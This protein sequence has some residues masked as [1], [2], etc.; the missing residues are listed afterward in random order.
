[1][2]QSDLPRIAEAVRE[3][4][5]DFVRDS[6]VRVA[7]LI[8][9]S[10]QVIAQHGFSRSLELVNV[11]SLA[12][13][14]HAASRTLARIA[15]SPAWQQTYHRGRTRQLFLAPLDMPT[16][17]L[18]LVAIFDE[19]SSVGLARLFFERFEERIR[20]LPVFG[21]ARPTRK[22]EDFEQDLEAGVQRL[23]PE[24]PPPEG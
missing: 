3:P 12:A 21:A 16:G 4:V 19:H 13:A 20:A 10:G 23:F 18:I 24:R 8:S 11:A 17:E 22:A 6:R 15:G 1:M 5:R 14:A 9:D 7:V 2:R